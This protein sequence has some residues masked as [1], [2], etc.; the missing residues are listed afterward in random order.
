MSSSQ[1]EKKNSD[2]EMG[3]ASPVLPIMVIHE[4]T[5][6]FTAGFLSFKERLSR[7]SAEKETSRTSAEMSAIP[8]SSVLS[9]SVEGNKSLSDVAHL[10][11]TDTAPVQV[12]EVMAQPS[13]SSTTPVPIPE[14]G[15]V[16]ESMPPPL[17]RKE[18]VLGLHAPSATPLPKGRKRNGSATETAKKRRCSKGAE[19][20]P[21]GPLPQYC[22]KFIS[23]IDGMISDCG[24]EVERLTE[25]LAE[26][27]EAL[28]RIEATLKSTE[29]AHA[30]ETSQLEVQVSGLERDL[31]KLASALFRMK[32]EKKA[33]ASEVRRLQRQI[34][35]Q[36]EPLPQYR[37]K[38]IS[39]IDGMISDCGSEVERLTEGLAESREALKRIEATLK[40]TEDAHAAETSQLEVQSVIFSAKSRTREPAGTVV[41]RDEFHARLT[42][43]AVLFDSLMAVRKKDLALAGIEGGLGG[44]DS[45]L[46]LLKSECTLTPSLEETEGQGRAA[47]EGEGDAVDRGDGEVAE[48]GDGDA[49]PSSDEVEDEGG[50]PRSA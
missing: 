31:E 29:D 28:K 4:A 43:M 38:F 17:D 22:A 26:S 24:S 15:Q 27:R 14:K 16:M 34:Q 36:E 23:L 47:E 6:T 20:E 10:V 18:I 8:S 12:P 40:S 44:F 49:V 46:S 32:K 21:S 48:G 45:I 33:K 3:E 35:S 19:G 39:L 2:V 9:I 7:R 13:G 37:A 25:G 41:P 42:R 1:N 11:G 50:A 5:P 30:A